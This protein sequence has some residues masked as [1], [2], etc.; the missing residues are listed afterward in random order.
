MGKLY[1]NVNRESPNGK[2]ISR[3]TYK[4]KVFSD[5]H[6]VFSDPHSVFSDPH[7]V[8]SDHH[9]VFKSGRNIARITKSA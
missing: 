8:F 1:Q 6:S 9:S 2:V 7:S 5:H 4:R 3:G